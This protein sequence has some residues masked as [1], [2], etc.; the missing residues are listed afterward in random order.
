MCSEGA[1]TIPESQHSSFATP[2]PLARDRVQNQPDKPANNG[3]VDP[4]ELKIATDRQLD[5][6]RRRGWIPAAHSVRD[7]VAH[8]RLIPFDKAEHTIAQPAVDALEQIIVFQN[9]RS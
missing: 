7:Q 6:L 2:R 8:F 5:S 9:R 1:G 3:A 4:D